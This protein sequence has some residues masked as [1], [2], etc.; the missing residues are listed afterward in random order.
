[1]SLF[2]QIIFILI[3]FLKTGNLLSENNLF[4]VNNILIEKKDKTSSNQLANE[5]INKGFIKFTKRVLLEED[6]KKV[7]DLDFTKIKELVT[8]YNISRIPNE[9]N[10]KINFSITFDREKIHDLFYNRGISYSDILNKEFYILPILLKKNEIFIFSN[11]YFYEN[12]NKPNS[13]NEELIEFILPLENIEI[14]QNI[15][16][17]RKNLLTLELNNLFQEYEKKN[18]AIVLISDNGLDSE[19][20]FLKAKVQEKNI[21]K[22]LTINRKN[23][24]QREFYDDIMFQIKEEIVNLVKSQNLIDIRTPSFINAKLDLDSKSNLVILNTRIKKIELIENTFVQ[25]FNKDYVNIRIKYLG[26][27]EK[28]INQLRSEKVN[29]EL[30]NEEW[31][32]K[33]L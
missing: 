28:I 7:S 32:I 18:T 8:Y 2:K 21:S 23:F 20:I 29:L 16:K 33:I 25:E 12:W 3:V 9:E 30:I 11:N 24:E 5:A 13:K 19:K 10:D 31:F 15:S 1:M 6:L 22:N 4:N 14:I 17:N 27:L 26:K